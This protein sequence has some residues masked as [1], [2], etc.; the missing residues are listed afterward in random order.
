MSLIP[1]SLSSAWF[2]KCGIRHETSAPYTPEQNGVAERTNRTLLDCVRCM[3]I[4]SGLPPT[5]WA[6]AVSYT[7]YVRNR[8]LSR[9]SKITPFEHW[10]GRK[11]NVSDIRIFGSRAFVRVPDAAKLDARS[12]EGIFVGRCNTQNASRIFIPDTRKIVVSKDVKIDEEVLYR[13]MKDLPPLTVNKS[14]KNFFLPSHHSFLYTLFLQHELRITDTEDE[15]MDVDNAEPITHPNDPQPDEASIPSTDANFNENRPIHDNP[16]INR[17]EIPP[18]TTNHQRD[19][20]SPPR[21]VRQ[22][23]RAPKY[24]ERFLEWQQSL[25]KQ[26]TLSSTSAEVQEIN[27]PS[28]P[29]EP[30][31]YL[32]AI[33]C[34]DSKYWIPAI[35]E[36]YDSL[37]QNG[38]WTLCPLPPNRQAIQGKWVMKFKPGFK[39]TPAR[40]KARFV[41][42]GYSQVF[43]LDYTETYAPVA[44]NYSLRLILAIAAAK[45][46]EMIQLDVKT[47]FLYGT[48]DEEI[49]MKQPEGFVI[50]GKEKEVCRLIKS[51][52]G[53]KQASRV[54]N[55][56]FKDFIIKFGLTRSQADPCI[57]YRHLRPGEADEELTIFIL[58]V[59]DGLILS[60]IKSILTDMVEFLGKEFE[61]RSLPADRFIGIDINRNRHLGTIHLSQP[62]YVKKILGRFNMSNCN[63]LAVPADPCVKLSPQM[64]PQNKEEKQEMTNVPFMECIGSVMHLT[65]LT[66]P[67]IAY[68]V[69]QVSRYSQNP[70]KEHWKALK[71]ILAYLKKTINFGL[72]FGGGSSEICGYCDSDYAGD[73]ESRRSTSGAVFTLHNGAVS[74]FSRRQTCVA[75][76]TT[77]A[78]FI[79]AAEGTKEGI[80]LK[81][82]HL[83]LGATESATPLRCDN[84]G[85]IALIHDPVFHQ[86][87]KAYGCAFLLHTGRSTRGTD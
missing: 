52:Y 18:N 16:T 56:K 46:L 25:A 8:V 15:E 43:G 77:E 9:T 34:A 80:W 22:S 69:G 73:L 60:N 4:S 35:F 79:S 21:R 19:E 1:F 72:L 23:S 37:I 24:S 76:S 58:Y 30:S 87:T 86:R 11:P 62:E 5:L 82:L 42:K 59:D 27:T 74:W 83:E 57:Y 32:E 44:K 64:S 53:L 70:G 28:L 12:Q 61:V 49:Y 65:H 7:T 84:Q 71:R 14:K 29:L 40:Y 54:W 38:T 81:R 75:L 17:D 33:S 68:A 63:P 85:A 10:N 45:N 78:E 47:A 20:D 6:E 48:L 41:I 36:E 31:S 3:I 55:I 50:P 26:A 39:S 13:D 2:E 67:D 51:I 66:R